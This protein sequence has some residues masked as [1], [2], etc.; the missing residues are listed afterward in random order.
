[1]LLGGWPPAQ[2]R[3]PR[4]RVLRPADVLYRRDL[5]VLVGV[6][7]STEHL[8]V[9]TLEIG[10][11]EV[12][13]LHEHGGDEVLMALF[14]GGHCLITGV[15]GLA[16][17][18]AVET[19]ASAV[20]GS[21]VRLQNITLGYTLDIPAFIGGSPRPVRVYVSGDNLLLLTDYKGYDPEVHTEAGLASR[22]IEYV[23]YPRPRTFTAG[24][25]VQF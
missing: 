22:G 4:L 17:T 19:L 23:T 7:V 20:G 18:L 11:G 21:F 3:E 24:V 13:A 15:P 16:K 2:P 1:M 6:L 12:A 10:P 25:R 5:D 8:T 14:T 9:A